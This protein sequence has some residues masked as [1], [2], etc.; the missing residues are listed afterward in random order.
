MLSSRLAELINPNGYSQ[1]I[2]SISII[3]SVQN[4]K[5]KLRKMPT[6]EKINAQQ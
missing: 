5:G 1:I 3:T 2:T 6:R 4:R